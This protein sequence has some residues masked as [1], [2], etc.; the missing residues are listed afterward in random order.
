M[1]FR[2]TLGKNI[3]AARKK[4]KFSAETIAA[5]M[6]NHLSTY[7]KHESGQHAMS[8]DDLYRFCTIV[9][10]EPASLFPPVKK[11]DI[12][13]HEKTAKKK[14]VQTVVVGYKMVRI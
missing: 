2:K 8:V 10:V 9:G 6:G 4:S 13:A 1:T 5:L 3:I 7:Y 12:K 14:V 11:I